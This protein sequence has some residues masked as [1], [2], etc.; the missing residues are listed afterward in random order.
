M[1]DPRAKATKEALPRRLPPWLKRPLVATAATRQLERSLREDCLHT[2]CEEA[3]CPNSGECF[4]RGTATFLILG[5]ICTRSCGFCG[6]AHGSPRPVDADEPR[7]VIAAIRRMGISHAVATSV[8][9]DDLPDGGASLFAEIIERARRELP[10]VSMEVLVPDFNGN[11][12]ALNAVLA[13]GPN[14]FNHNVETV[15]RLYPAVRPQAD[16][17]RSLTMLAYAAARGPDVKVKSGIMVGL[18]ESYAEVESTLSDL[19]SFGC[20]IVT[21]GQYL[22]PSQSQLPV[23]EY[24]TPEQFAAY[25]DLA[26]GLGFFGVSSGPF[27]RS[28]YHAEEFVKTNRPGN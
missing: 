14:V 28:S 21:I 3:H 4:T 20:E 5:D 12:T 25:R 1:I 15:A 13:A 16:Y 22:R 19:R 18:G 23:V 2:V 26:L 6:I 7:R 27:V 24:I 9:R 17:Q 8:T 10:A 11:R